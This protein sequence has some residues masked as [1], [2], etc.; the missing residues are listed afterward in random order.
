VTVVTRRRFG[1]P[2]GVG[3]VLSLTLFFRQDGPSSAENLFHHP[4]AHRGPE[5]RSR[6]A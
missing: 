2:F 1:R 5:A 3:L 4:H 6:G